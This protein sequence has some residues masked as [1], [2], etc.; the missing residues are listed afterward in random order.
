MEYSLCWCVFAHCLLARHRR[1]ITT[2][3]LKTP[4]VPVQGQLL[5]PMAVTE[6]V[7]GAGLPDQPHPHCPQVKTT[8][9][10]L[11]SSA[12]EAGVK[13]SLAVRPEP[14]ESVG[15]WLGWCCLRAPSPTSCSSTRSHCHSL[16]AAAS[17][18]HCW[19]SKPGRPWLEHS[20][21]SSSHCPSQDPGAVLAGVSSSSVQ[22]PGNALHLLT[23]SC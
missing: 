23:S 6:K 1:E 12:E 22:Q 18:F 20:F 16:G 19:K 13:L 15:H 5:F 14:P 10:F 8:R 11:P 21:S 7:A 4:L 3:T 2:I 17:G 9:L